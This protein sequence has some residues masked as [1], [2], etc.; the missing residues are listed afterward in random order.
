MSNPRGDL[1]CLPC[2]IFRCVAKKETIV[3]KVVMIILKY[4][5]FHTV[6][7]RNEGFHTQQ[8]RQHNSY[9]FI[10]NIWQLAN[11]I[12]SVPAVVITG[13]VTFVQPL[14]IFHIPFQ[15]S[16]MSKHSNRKLKL[17]Q[18]RNNHTFTHQL[19]LPFTIYSLHSR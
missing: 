7:I 18:L 6:P 4:Y 9:S 1:T 12:V 16:T 19:T 3:L 15:F 11:L 8:L 5:T 17:V 13:N 10:L 14:Y 2:R